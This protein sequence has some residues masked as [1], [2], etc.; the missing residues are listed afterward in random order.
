MTRNM[1]W[2]VAAG[3]WMLGGG[4]ATA[5]D[6]AK[7]TVAQWGFLSLDA[8]LTGTPS[9]A[10]PIDLRANIQQSLTLIVVNPSEIDNPIVSV[11]ISA[12]GQTIAT[13]EAPLSGKGA[14]KVPLKA[15]A[16]TTLPAT[17]PATPPNEAGSA[18]PI[19]PT[20]GKM[21]LT[22]SVVNK[23]RVDDFSPNVKQ[24]SVNIKLPD[25]YLGETTAKFTGTNKQLTVNVKANNFRGPPAAVE[26]MLSPDDV[27]GLQ[28][29]ELKGFT[30]D[31]LTEQKKEL[32]LFAS[33]LALTPGSEGVGRATLTVDKVERAV[34]LRG[35]F[36]IQEGGRSNDFSV[37]RTVDLRVM[38]PS[39]AR[40]GQPF[41]VRIE[42]ANLPD[43]SALTLAFVPASGSGAV[44]GQTITKNGS[45]DQS[46]FA[47]VD[48][49]V[50]KMTTESKN[51]IIN[52]DTRGMFGPYTLKAFT[53]SGTNAKDVTVYFDD[54]PPTPVKFQ[55]N[56][57][58]TLPV[59]GRNYEVRA[60]CDDKESQ[61][62]K[63]EFFVGAEPPPPSPDGKESPG[64]KP[65]V[66]VLG[67]KE[68]GGPFWYAKIPL[69]EK[70]GP[71]MVYVRATNRVGLFAV[72]KTELEVV[73]SSP[74]GIRGQAKYGQ[75]VQIED[76]NVW[77]VSK[78][79]KTIVKEGSVGK[80]GYFE[81][82]PIPAGDYQLIA[83]RKVSGRPLYGSMNVTVKDGPDLTP[84]TMTLKQQ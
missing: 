52:F 64:P 5:Q 48:E 61:I 37:D 19:D 75:L 8:T 65:I 81:L 36:K 21:L 76:V 55:P 58:K 10:Q 6:A 42:S 29:G 51:W 14:H 11:S 68:P 4:G 17:P 1:P 24:Q 45:R 49:G 63:V 23:A 71:T 73:E 26:L 20:T 77:V 33:D 7:P 60:N 80:D 30:R 44:Q 40:P 31:V 67:P 47:K 66:G 13:G 35:D 25:S 79:G 22:V 59:K 56:D 57:S 2:M 27:P 39:A 69:P 15:A 84:V 53:A 18:I 34:V 62:S 38:A 54:T 28:K 46:A 41:A 50:L 82:K 32:T 9:S 74:G 78:D 83:Q 70:A 3:I 12:G 43:N 16:P 72:D